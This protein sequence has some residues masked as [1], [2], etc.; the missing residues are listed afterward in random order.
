MS[1]FYCEICGKGLD[2]DFVD[3]VEYGNG[4]ACLECAD[5]EQEEMAEEAK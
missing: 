2:S 1:V 3:I 4:L 5:E